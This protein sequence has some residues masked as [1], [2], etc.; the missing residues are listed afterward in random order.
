MR[1]KHRLYIVD[2]AN[3]IGFTVN[4]ELYEPEEGAWRFR[5]QE[6]SPSSRS[7]Y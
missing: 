5:S 2:P 6:L 4:P 1:R 7:W 3:A